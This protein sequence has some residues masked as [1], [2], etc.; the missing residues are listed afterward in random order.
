MSGPRSR[1]HP[2]LWEGQLGMA[3]AA[4]DLVPYVMLAFSAI[5]TLVIAHTYNESPLIALALCGLAAAWTLCM[6]T[7]HPAWRD[8]PRLMAVFVVVLLA[9]MTVMVTRY[10]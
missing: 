5:L 3:R 4:V 1:S 6:Y 2:D 9:I 10:S 8:R 7:L